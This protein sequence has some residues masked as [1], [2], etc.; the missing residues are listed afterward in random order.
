MEA[1]GCFGVGDGA[2]SGIDD[3]RGSRRCER[4][5]AR[6]T[7]ARG[8][9]ETPAWRWRWLTAKL[10]AKLCLVELPVEPRDGK[11]DEEMRKF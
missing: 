4:V 3:Q 10:T 2:A 8:A 11:N 5:W 1:R 6:H 9:E 7:G